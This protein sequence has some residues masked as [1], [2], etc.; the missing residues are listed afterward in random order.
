MQSKHTDKDY[1]DKMECTKLKL[2]TDIKMF[3][4]AVDQ[5][6]QLCNDLTLKLY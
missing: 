6:H 2:V 1:K 5:L 3:L 4:S